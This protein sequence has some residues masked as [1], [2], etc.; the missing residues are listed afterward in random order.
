MKNFFKRILTLI[1]TA[2]LCMGLVGCGRIEHNAK[3][4]TVDRLSYH[5]EWLENN[6]VYGAYS[7]DGKENYN[8]DT[9]KN[10]TYLIQTQGQL[11]EIFVDFPEIDFEKEMVLVYCYRTVYTQRKQIL[12]NVTLDGKVLNVSFNVERGKLG[13][14]DASA[15]HR[16]ILVVKLDKLEITEVKITYQGQ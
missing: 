11:N 13:Y 8:S 14:A 1:M 4:I 7:E 10:R 15:P 3:I 5:A 12:E 16:R 6:P 9:P 2:F